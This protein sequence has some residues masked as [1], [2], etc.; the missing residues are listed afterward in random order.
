MAGKDIPDVSQDFIPCTYPPRLF[1]K[2]KKGFGLSEVNTLTSAD[3]SSPTIQ[4]TNAETHKIN[5]FT[6]KNKDGWWK[7]SDS[8]K[9]AF[10]QE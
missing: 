3:T 7:R 8:S 10:F 4:S 5:G 2:I 1:Q 6:F 9:S